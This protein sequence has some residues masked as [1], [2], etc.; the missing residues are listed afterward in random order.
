MR[1]LL[2]TTALAMFLAACGGSGS[3]PPAPSASSPP[4][5]ASSTP[6]VSAPIETTE[7]ETETVETAEAETP[8]TEA[9]ATVTETAAA[10]GEE[11]ISVLMA[12]LPA[13]Y[14]AAD[15]TSG[16]R[17]FKQCATCH[18]LDPKE[19]H[20]V[21]PNLHGLFGREAGSLDDF[22]YSKV[23]KEADFIWE[24]HELDAWLAGPKKY[25]P[26]NRMSF[27]GVPRES[28]R[29][30]VIAYLLIETDR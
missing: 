21:G 7:V 28:Q 25:L 2:T 12:A 9:P 16:Q 23:L 30:D 22:K 3:E 29:N 8:A 10:E 19:G 6:Q 14:N 4:A 13:P 18:R 17:V 20:R 15:Y 26:G 1:K 11:D 5:E 27:A 24:P